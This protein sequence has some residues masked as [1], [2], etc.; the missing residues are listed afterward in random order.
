[1]QICVCYSSIVIKFHAIVRNISSENQNFQLKSLNWVAAAEA[2]QQQQQPPQQGSSRAC[3]CVVYVRVCVC[4][5]ACDC[6]SERVQVCVRV[7][8]CLQLLGAVGCSFVKE[9]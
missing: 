6:V 3:V 4:V 2:A 7:F 5:R 8:V 9:E 1:M